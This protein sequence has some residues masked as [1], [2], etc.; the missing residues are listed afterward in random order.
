MST[1]NKS[2]IK[3]QKYTKP[4][5]K[6]TSLTTQLNRRSVDIEAMLNLFAAVHHLAEGY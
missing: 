1:L 5:I 3:R 6:V 2:F 4:K